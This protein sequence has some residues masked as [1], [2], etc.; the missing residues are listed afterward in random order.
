M[1]EIADAPPY[2]AAVKRWRDEVLRLQEMIAEQKQTRTRLI[3]VLYVGLPFAV[4]SFFWHPA[5]P[6]GVIAFTVTS[7]LT[8]R[9]FSWG[10][11]IERGYQL[12]MAEIELRKERKKAGLPERDESIYAPPAS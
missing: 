8:G 3:W 6:F 11:L 7:W 5:A 10:H 1:T 4:P 2:P 9:Y 12:K